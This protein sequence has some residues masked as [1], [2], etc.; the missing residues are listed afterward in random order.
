MWLFKKSFIVVISVQLVFTSSFLYVV[1]C[2]FYPWKEVSSGSSYSA[3]LIT[4]PSKKNVHRAV[5]GKN[6]LDTSVKS[7][8]SKVLF[9]SNMSLIIFCLDDPSIANSG[10]LKS[11]T[12]NVLSLHYV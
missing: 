1:T 7:I 10:V 9:I 6:G 4:P 3:V 2:L 8:C 11:S 5:Y 12:L